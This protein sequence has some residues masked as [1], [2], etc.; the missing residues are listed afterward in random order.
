MLALD[1]AGVLDIIIRLLGVVFDDILGI[2]N[3]VL[4]LDATDVS[5]S[6]YS[7]QYFG[8]RCEHS[9]FYT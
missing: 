1:V 3:S 5:S 4:V 9:R 2:K 6:S 8:Y 7:I